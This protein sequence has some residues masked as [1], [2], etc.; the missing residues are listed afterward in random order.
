MCPN[1]SDRSIVVLTQHS[2]T[3]LDEADDPNHVT[4]D[5]QIRSAFTTDLST[6]LDYSTGEALGVW[7]LPFRLRPIRPANH[8]KSRGQPEGVSE[9]GAADFVCM[10]SPGR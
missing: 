9:I 6:M 8:E 1:E 4:D 2:P 7:A 5:A 3:A 10:Q